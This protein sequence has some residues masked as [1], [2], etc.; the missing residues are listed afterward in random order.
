MNMI[1]AAVP[2][3]LGVLLSISAAAQGPIASDQ[4]ASSGP[5]M[6]PTMMRVVPYPDEIYAL[7]EVAPVVTYACYRIGRCSAYD[8]YR[9]RDRPNRLTRLAPEAPPEDAARLSLFQYRWVLVP[10]TP[11]ENIR[12]KYRTASKVREEYRAVGTPTD[13]PN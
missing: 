10:V 7:P 13:G 5:F 8:L 9:F 1:R 2:G 3:A 6:E 4:P 11:E 12:P